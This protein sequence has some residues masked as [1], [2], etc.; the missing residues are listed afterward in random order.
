VRNIEFL[1]T[2]DVANAA[3]S[4]TS[5]VRYWRRTGRLVPAAV[6]ARNQALYRRGDVERFLHERQRELDADDAA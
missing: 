6:T 5:T 3:Q 2:V 4:D 1:T